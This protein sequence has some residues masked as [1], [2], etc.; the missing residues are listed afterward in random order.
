MIRSKKG[1]FFFDCSQKKLMVCLN[2][3]VL[4]AMERGPKDRVT[5]E[6]RCSFPVGTDRPA[7]RRPA[8]L[9][10]PVTPVPCYGPASRRNSAF[11]WN[12]VVY[13]LYAVV[14]YSHERSWLSSLFIFVKLEVLCDLQYLS[15]EE[16]SL[17]RSYLSIQIQILLILNR[18]KKNFTC[19]IIPRIPPRVTVLGARLAR[20]H[21][22]LLSTTRKLRSS[23]SLL[24]KPWPTKASPRRNLHSP[25]GHSW[26]RRLLFAFMGKAGTSM[27]RPCRR[28]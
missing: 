1:R 11:H 21:P 25:F 16:S 13:Q 24:L 9:D 17:S 26:P 15:E 20:R 22:G 10:R 23:S 19:L 3:S 28:S 14:T 4:P 12:T 27:A 7:R 5:R 2:E 8:A 18:I 6:E